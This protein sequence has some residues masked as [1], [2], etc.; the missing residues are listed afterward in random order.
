MGRQKDKTNQNTFKHAVWGIKYGFPLSSERI[1]FRNGAS[2]IDIVYEN[3]AP[4]H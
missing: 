1:A 4:V 3:P 2:S